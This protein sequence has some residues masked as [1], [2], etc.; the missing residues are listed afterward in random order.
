MNTSTERVLHTGLFSND[1]KEIFESFF[2]EARKNAD[3]RRLSK[4]FG[5]VAVG[6]APDG[7]VLLILAL[8]DGFDIYRNRCYSYSFWDLT[9]AEKSKIWIARRMKE[10]VIAA[11]RTDAVWNR[12][13]STVIAALNAS[14]SSIYLIYD[15]LL[16]RVKL[17]RKYDADT[18]KRIVGTQ[19][20]PLLTEMEMNRRA[21]IVRIDREYEEAKRRAANERQRLHQEYYK[22]LC[23]DEESAIAA[24][25]QKHDEEISALL[26]AMKTVLT[27]NGH[28]NDLNMLVSNSV[29]Y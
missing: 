27:A 8:C 29:Q 5:R 10:H 28:A 16:N 9:T 17:E 6:I 4:A 1:A 2:R 19:R 23:A 13:N 26:D 15:I 14:V 3:S 7:E 18:Y 21:E 22:K 25:K 24:A 11:M 20:D 12:G